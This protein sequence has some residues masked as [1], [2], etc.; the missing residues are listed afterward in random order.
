MSGLA[1]YIPL[2]NTERGRENLRSKAYKTLVLISGGGKKIH[3]EWDTNPPLNLSGSGIG[4]DKL[5]LTLPQNLRFARMVRSEF[6]VLRYARRQK[7]GSGRGRA[8]LWLPAA[9][10]HTKPGFRCVIMK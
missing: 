7:S 4:E 2:P 9:V 6:Y 10:F 5:G 1:Q 3:K 8:L